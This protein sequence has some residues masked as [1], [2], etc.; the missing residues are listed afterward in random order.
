M[1]S[2]SPQMSHAEVQVDT[3]CWM[4]FLRAGLWIPLMMASVR[5]LENGGGSGSR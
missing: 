3:W 4:P 2:L 5:L 1:C